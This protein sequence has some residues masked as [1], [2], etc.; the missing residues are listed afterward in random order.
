[1]LLPLSYQHTMVCLSDDA[2]ANLLPAKCAQQRMLQ[3]AG[4]RGRNRSAAR[5]IGGPLHVRGCSIDVKHDNSRYPFAGYF[6]QGPNKSVAVLRARDD[7]VCY[8]VPVDSR[9]HKVVL[10]PI[11]IPGRSKP[12]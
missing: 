6:V 3:R 2:T 8:G 9:D 12:L 10:R 11:S 1:M 5:T 7:V 4:L